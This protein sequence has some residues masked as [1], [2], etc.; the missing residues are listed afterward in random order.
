MADGSDDAE[1]EMLITAVVM[2]VGASPG[3][4]LPGS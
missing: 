4:V 1:F 3:D 2:S